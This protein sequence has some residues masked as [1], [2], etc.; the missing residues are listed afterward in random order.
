MKYLMR[1]FKNKMK[2][3]YLLIILIPFIFMGCDLKKG[4]D[5]FFEIENNYIWFRNDIIRLR[6]DNKMFIKVFYEAETLGKSL[7]AADP[8]EFL[9]KPPNY[10]VVNGSEI[11]N[12]NLGTEIP[13]VSMIS[14]EFGTGKR[15]ILKGISDESSGIKI[16]KQ[17]II[18]IYDKFP[19]TAIIYTIYKNLESDKTITIEKVYSNSFRLDASLVKTKYKPYEFWSFQGVYDYYNDWVIRITKNFSRTNYTGMRKVMSGNSTYFTGQGIP[20]IDLWIKEMGVAIAMIEKEPKI[21][22]FP[23]NVEYDETVRIGILEEPKIMLKPNENYQTYKYVI[24]V[25]KLDYFIPLNRFQELMA[26]LGKNVKKSPDIAYYPYWSTSGFGDNFTLTDIYNRFSELKELGVGW[27]VIDKGWFDFSGDWFPIKKIFPSG[28]ESIKEIVYLIHKNGFRAMLWWIPLTVQK[29]SYVE[30]EFSDWFILN[31]NGERMEDGMGSYYLCPA[32]KNVREFTVSL[33][34]E[35]IKDWGFDG[36]YIDGTSLNSVP[37]CYAKHHNHQYPSETLNSLSDLFKLIYET[38]TNFN[39]EFV[40]KFYSDEINPSIYNMF[41][42]N[43]QVIGSPTSRFQIRNR[44]KAFKALF[45]NQSA[46]DCNYYERGIWDF[47]SHIAPGGVIS[48]KFTDLNSKE[49]KKI[50][51]IWFKIYNEKK[52]YNGEYLNLYDIGYD[53]PETHVIKKGEKFYYSFF[54]PYWE[55]K[56]ELRGLEKKK[57]SV[58]DYLHN[59]DLGNVK[60]PKGKI[61]I[62]FKEFLLL[63]LTPK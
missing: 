54:S 23:V 41:E 55:G 38:S 49:A 11:K 30:K 1:N 9:A 28:E 5:K 45:G 10:V 60:G 8:I 26:I 16:E 14:T 61:E 21:V 12:F 59:I 35:F 3:Y 25:H 2:I 31:E 33:V 63:E 50:Y 17:V 37:F 44:I 47:A 18:E 46:V 29:G 7:T 34:N 53:K 57:Y 15:L 58:F 24:V 20:L 56:L 39:P 51:N 48:V 32:N 40:I 52:L 6:I 13:Q 62:G 42:C 19:D 36:F 43:V 27:I 4:S 22:S